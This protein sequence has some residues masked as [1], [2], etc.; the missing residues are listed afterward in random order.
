MLTRLVFDHQAERLL[1]LKGYTRQSVPTEGEMV[2]LRSTGN[3]STGGTAVDKTD[4]V[5]PD[6]REMADRAAAVWARL[7]DEGIGPPVDHEAETA[8]TTGKSA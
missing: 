2:F 8:K 4:A 7:A 6:N 3:L 1:E 5:H